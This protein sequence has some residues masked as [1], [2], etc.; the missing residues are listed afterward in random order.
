MATKK[1][2]VLD[3]DVYLAYSG[4]DTRLLSHVLLLL[5]RSGLTIS[6]ELEKS[7]E[8][9]HEG[10]RAEIVSQAILTSKMALFLLSP[11]SVSS[12][13]LA[14]ELGV[15]LA[16]RKTILTAVA[17]HTPSSAIPGPLSK[18]RVFRQVEQDVVAQELL[19]QLK[20]N[21]GKAA[22]GDGV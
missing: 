9:S 11:D 5:A 4:S 13:F 14:F 12:N 17:M 6:F 16:A 8:P 10:Y 22:V 2:S 21:S 15:A 1:R 7:P 18:R 20:I 19:R 3:T